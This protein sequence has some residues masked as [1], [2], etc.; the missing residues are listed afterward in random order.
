[1]VAG[2]SVGDNRWAH[3]LVPHLLWVWWLHRLMLLAVL[4][5]SQLSH[6]L[7]YSHNFLAQMHREIIGHS[8][9][10]IHV[11]CQVRP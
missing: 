9:L 2:K 10:V 1:L 7:N 6:C 11:C 3:L 4:G 8:L 5:I